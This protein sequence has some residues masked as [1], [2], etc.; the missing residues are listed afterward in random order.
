MG[1]KV[2]PERGD[3]ECECSKVRKS[4]EV[5]QRKAL[6]ASPRQ[7]HT[8]RGRIS[9]SGGGGGAAPGPPAG[10]EIHL[11]PRFFGRTSLGPAFHI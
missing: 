6:R 10:Q 11:V 1:G 8:R 7:I 9:L 3:V 2:A 5:A 4:N